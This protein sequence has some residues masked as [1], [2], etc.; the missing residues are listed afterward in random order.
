MQRRRRGNLSYTPSAQ[1]SHHKKSPAALNA[2]YNR[3]TTANSR[4]T[5]SPYPD[6]TSQGMHKPL[7][8][9]KRTSA[10]LA[11]P[12]NQQPDSSKPPKASEAQK[13]EPPE[14]TTYWPEHKKW[15][16]ADAAQLALTSTSLNVGKMITSDEIHAL[17]DRNPSYSQ[18]CEYLENKSFVI[19]RGHFARVLLAAVPDIT[20]ARPPNNIA[21]SQAPPPK[22]PQATTNPPTAP[23]V[24]LPRPSPYNSSN[25]NMTPQAPFPSSQERN[26]AAPAYYPVGSPFS[27]PEEKQDGNITV[28]D[29]PASAQAQSKQEK[30]KKRS[31]GDI[32]DLTTTSD[33]EGVVRRRPIPRVDRINAPDQ[34][35]SAQPHTS[36]FASAAFSGA[37][38]PVLAPSLPGQ[39]NVGHLKPPKS[40][41]EHL[42]YD[43][44]VEPMN[45][46]RD[47]LRR[48]SYDSRTICRDILIA[49]GRHPTM[50]PLNQHLDAL[51]EKFVSV[52]N[53]ADLSTFRWDLVDPGGH[54]PPKPIEH[55][56]VQ[57]PD[58]QDADKN[59][60]CTA[61]TDT[62][63]HHPPQIA[64]QIGRLSPGSG[65]PTSVAHPMN[66][67]SKPLRKGRPPM[68]NS[69]VNG[70]PGSDGH[71]NSTPESR[72]SPALSTTGQAR[73]EVTLMPTISST[74]V[75]RPA[76]PNLMPTDSEASSAEASPNTPA[77][78]PGRRGRPPGAKNKQPRPDKGFSRKS[79]LSLESTPSPTT[80]SLPS[81]RNC[82]ISTPMRPSGLRN[83][84]TPTSGVAVVIPSRSP[85]IAETGSA[86]KARGMIKQGEPS[87]RHS[88]APSYKIYKCRW[89]HCPAELHNLDT[90]RKHIRKQHRE[91][92]GDGP[93]PCKWADCSDDSHSGRER[94]VSDRGEATG[95]D[96]RGGNGKR[97]T[98]EVD[99]AWDTHMEIKHLSEY[100]SELGD[101][102]AAYR[103]GTFP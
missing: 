76:A 4:P 41:R 7:E 27:K 59:Y 43:M 2:G 16:I 75:S 92:L 15:A 35:Y 73:Q 24:S 9:F 85:S 89:G 34:K 29:D 32:V 22:P 63:T 11:N 64:V 46:R 19:E 81:H 95:S 103:S 74:P 70:S 52:E 36:A 49:S 84:V 14:G 42:L 102:P 47:A 6:P 58:H 86:K 69:R 33:D 93:W 12:P 97:L 98:F 71:P 50:A 62:S 80:S 96:E 101:G 17:L 21:K 30:A 91:R 25:G 8:Q 57:S 78:V 20:S 77:L 18:M 40:G 28:K 82:E 65:Q 39:P 44:V 60:A 54:P 100:V 38:R 72:L 99:K 48:S 83:V 23:S 90:L 67:K 68:Y 51:R 10:S 13:G 1:P 55:R 61:T 53:N 31:F 88:S 79:R 66:T 37:Q 45:R 94:H 87:G 56:V 26:L 5:Q 3:N